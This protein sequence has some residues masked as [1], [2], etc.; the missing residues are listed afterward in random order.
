MSGWLL[1]VCVGSER[2]KAEGRGHCLFMLV[3]GRE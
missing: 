1:L 2:I 3:I